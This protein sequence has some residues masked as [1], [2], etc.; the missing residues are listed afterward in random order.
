MPK[1]KHQESQE[2]QSRRLQQTVRALVVAGELNPIAAYETKEKIIG[3]GTKARP[4]SN[5]SSALD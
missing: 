2:D 4:E 5:D 3:S 1:K